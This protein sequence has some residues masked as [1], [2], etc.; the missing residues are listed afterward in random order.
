MRTTKGTESRRR[1]RRRRRRRRN[2]AFFFVYVVAGN[3]TIL[4][5]ELSSHCTVVVARQAHA[6]APHAG[7]EEGGNQA[8]AEFGQQP[9]DFLQPF[10]Q[11]VVRFP[12]LL[13]FFLSF[14]SFLVVVAIFLINFWW[15]KLSCWELFPV[16]SCLLIFLSLCSQIV[17]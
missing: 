1:G 15:F 5:Q 14:F 4:S 8:V 16:C 10:P 9:L 3:R 12:N 6:I 11:H 17:R 7:M 13:S 2:G